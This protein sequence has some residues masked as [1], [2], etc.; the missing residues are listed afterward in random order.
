MKKLILNVLI[1]LTVS[2][3]L[4]ISLDESLDL[5]RQNN[6][7]L[8]MAREET[9]KAEQSY[10]DVRGNYFPKLNLVGAYGLSK[11]YLP[12][13]VL[14]DPIDLT[15]YI[16]PMTASDNDYMLAGAVSGL[17][18][19]LMPAPI[20]NEGSLALSLQ[21]EQVLFAG[22]KLWYGSQALDRNI[23]VQKL[24]YGIRE[25]Q[26]ILEVT[27]SFYSYLLADKMVQVQEQAL[28]TARRH[29][30]RAEAFSSE[31]MVAEFDLLQARL[32]I[33][34][35]EPQL[36]LF[37]N[38]R[39]LVLAN[40]RTLIGN[41][42]AD[43]V[44]V[45]EFVLPSSIDLS[46]EES[47]NM[48][49]ENRSELEMA[50]LATDIWNLQWK[51]EKGNF[52]PKL[53]L[54]ASASLYTK[55]DDFAIAKDDFGTS[56]S[57][58]IGISVPLFS[59]LSDLAKRRYAEHNYLQAKL[60]ELD[61]EDMIRLEIT[62]NYQKLRFAEQNYWVQ[63]QNIQLAERGLQLAQIRY[64]NQVGIQLEVFDA[65]TTLSAIRLQYLKAIYDVIIATMELQKAIEIVL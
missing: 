27:Q 51:A 26:L 49:V 60:Q 47:L 2:S 21:L 40:F 55:A 53:A 34:K 45:G 64:E 20:L 12:D 37:R 35:L 10:Q 42:D 25:K 24:G 4:A 63:E 22:G 44:P 19:Q 7:T 18:N 8:L 13:S 31:G 62:Q 9:S 33:A 48:G 17:A 43:T 57:V 58:G 41:R 32:E 3:M 29:L 5:A 1:C 28:D 16:N 11:T 52:L 65:Q 39:D 30:A 38:N 14:T 15:Q 6:K 23:Q 50:A 54:Q 56:Y 46:L 61:A 59:G 36:L